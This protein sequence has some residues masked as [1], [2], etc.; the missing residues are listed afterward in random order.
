M[1]LLVFGLVNVKKTVSTSSSGVESESAGV[2]TG[3]G[4][5]ATLDGKKG[6]KATG[7]C[8]NKAEHNL[9]NTV[10]REK[11]EKSILMQ[12]K[13]IIQEKMVNLSC[14]LKSDFIKWMHFKHYNNVRM[15]MDYQHMI[16]RL[17]RTNDVDLSD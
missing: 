5:V 10:L 3:S 7:L 17:L 16:V 2:G 12:T 15:G 4:E 8:K 14:K 1:Q 9:L 6:S 13:I 11:H